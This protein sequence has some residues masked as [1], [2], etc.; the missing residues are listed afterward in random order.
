[1]VHR[2]YFGN[3]DSMFQFRLGLSQKFHLGELGYNPDP[4]ILGWFDLDWKCFDLKLGVMPFHLM[5]Q[6]HP[7]VFEEQSFRYE[8][9]EGM[10]LGYAS[11]LFSVNLWIDWVSRQSTENRE[12]FLLGLSTRLHFGF[13]FEWTNQATL[14][15]HAGVD[16]GPVELEE[17]GVWLSRL[18]HTTKNI[19]PLSFQSH[20]LGVGFYLPYSRDRNVSPTWQTTQ[21]FMAQWHMAFKYFGFEAEFMVGKKDGFVVDFRRP[22]FQA[23]RYL[24]LSPV[25]YI[26]QAHL[27]FR[28]DVEIINEEIANMQRLWVEYS[29]KID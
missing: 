20:K 6:M 28:W 17:N 10:N 26:P 22:V 27:E 12:A 8:T 11:R 13:G 15:H 2:V 16:G 18:V 24:Q 7:A 5:G 23:Q 1:M 4:K 14:F 9:F 21:K 25:L 19:G 3:T 29:Y